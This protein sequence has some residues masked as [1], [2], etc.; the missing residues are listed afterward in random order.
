MQSSIESVRSFVKSSPTCNAS[1][2]GVFAVALTHPVDTW[3]VNRQTSRA[4][5]FTPSSLYRGL[6]PAVSQAALIYGAM[7]GVYEHLSV[8]HNFSPLAAGALSAIPESLLKG[9]MEAM[10]NNKQTSRPI[11]PSGSTARLHFLFWST[12]GM[13]LREVPGNMC[14]FWTYVKC[15]EYKVSPFWSGAAAATAFTAAVYPLD[16][17]R[18]QKIT[19]VSTKFTFQGVVPFWIR[20]VIVTG[21]LFTAYE[22]L[23]GGM[24]QKLNVKCE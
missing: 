19:G 20:G 9:P 5:K 7:L 11:I 2:A 10:K 21:I 15:R 17:W 4:L 22:E 6:V 13:L 18:A 12:A 8:E 3:V 14:Y 24:S 23:N 16:A 1:L